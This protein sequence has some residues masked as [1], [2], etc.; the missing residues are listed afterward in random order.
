MRRKDREASYEQGIE[1]LK[2]AKYGILS[3][4][5]KTGTPYGVPV[6]FCLV[7]TYIYFHTART[8]QK[9]DYIPKNPLAC[10]CVV[11]DVRILAKQFTTLYK[12]VIVTGQIKEVFCREKEKVL[13]SLIQKYSPAYLLKGENYIRAFQHKVRAFKLSVSSLSCKIN[14]IS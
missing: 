2:K 8:G 4:S 11:E 1:I 10:F 13:K 5:S 7:D 12:S 14:D 9:I 6:N 3:L